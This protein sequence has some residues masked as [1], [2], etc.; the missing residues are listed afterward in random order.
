MR[1]GKQK[2]PHFYFFPG[3]LRWPKFQLTYA[4]LPGTREDA[5]NPAGGAFQKWAANTQFTFSRIDKYTDADITVSF[6]RGD[7][8][9]GHPFEGPHYG[10]L[11]LATAPT[12]WIFR[13]NGE[14]Q[15]SESV[16][17]D[18]FHLETV[19]LHAIGHLLGLEHTSDEMALCTQASGLEYPRI[20]IRMLLKESR[21][22]IR[23]DELSSEI[24]YIYVGIHRY[25]HEILIF[26]S[27]RKSS[28]IKYFIFDKIITAEKEK[29]L[30]FLF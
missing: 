25:C 29:S 30:Y 13:Y 11:A 27:Y 6:E 2:G 14:C 3:N 12:G 28:P 26:Q 18:S 19:A 21:L 8:N 20:W 22:Y 15:W 5:I 10:D 9:D 17:Q 23:N 7:H 4:F 16:T 24:L 1:S